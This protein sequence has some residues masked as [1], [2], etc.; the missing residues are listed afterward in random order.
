M[1]FKAEK[2]KKRLF[3][4]LISGS[5]VAMLLTFLKNASQGWRIFTIVIAVISGLL[6]LISFLSYQNGRKHVLKNINYLDENK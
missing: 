2:P 5:Y 3:I 4:E 6:A 1:D